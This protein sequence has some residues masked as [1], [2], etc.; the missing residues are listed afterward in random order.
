M[1]DLTGQLRSGRDPL[2]VDDELSHV[3][4]TELYGAFPDQGFLAHLHLHVPAI[5]PALQF[6]EQLGFVKNL[7]LPRMGFADLA[8]GGVYTHRLAVNIWA[9]SG[10]TP[11]PATSAKLLGYSLYTTDDTIFTAARSRLAEDARTGELVG[12]DPTGATLRLRSSLKQEQA[13]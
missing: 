3:G 4:S 8:T 10:V 12:I 7:H 11:A 13:A 5:E 1:I 2:D 6:F 9:G